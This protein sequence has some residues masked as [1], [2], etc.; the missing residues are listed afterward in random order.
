MNNCQCGIDFEIGD[1]SEVSF[2]FDS[3]QETLLETGDPV[4]PIETRNYE[5]LDNKPQINGV[6]LLGNKTSSQL[7]IKESDSMSNFDI[8]EVLSNI[9]N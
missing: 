2:M 9:F 1:E 5:I 4:I 6:E 3:E 7:K 8:E